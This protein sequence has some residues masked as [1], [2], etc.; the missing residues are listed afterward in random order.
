MC[1]LLVSLF[2]FLV[3]TVGSSPL[4]SPATSISTNGTISA[5]TLAPTSASNTC[6]DIATSRTR[7]TIV[8][9][10]LATILACVWTAVH[11]NVPGL[12]KADASRFWRIMGPVPEAAKI[13]VVTL[14]VPEWVLA[15][16]VR[17]FLTARA[18]E[19]ELEAA[20]SDAKAVWDAKIE[21]LR[22]MT[23]GTAQKEP[24]AVIQRYHKDGVRVAHHR[25]PRADWTARHGF[26]VITGGFHY[27]ENGEPQC[28]LSRWDAIEL[29]KTGGLVP[30]TEQEIRG[31]SQRN[32]LSK[33]F[34]VIQ[35]LWFIVQAAARSV[36]GPSLTQLAI[37]TLGYTTIT[38]AMYIAWWD[39]PQ[40]IGG[41]VRVSVKRLPEPK[42]AVELGRLRRLFRVIAGSQDDDVDLRRKRGVPTF[43]SGRN[44]NDDYD[45]YGDLVALA[46]AMVF[47]A[48]HC[49]AWNN[50]FPSHAEQV[51]WRFS[52]LAIIALPGVMLAATLL[53]WSLTWARA[54]TVVKVAFF[55][56]LVLAF[57]VVA[58]VYVAARSLLLVLSFT[59]L[60]SLPLD[61]YEAVQWTLLIPHFT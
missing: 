19:R 21:L 2:P 8:C 1:L 36:E 56:M 46:A 6:T 58:P 41:P 51:I 22:E 54:S 48:V 30:P 5:D 60:R 43:Y 27:Y 18:V 53:L 17:Q 55:F 38:V 57:V 15:W 9:S 44:K 3:D 52:S 40:N 25:V 33:I 23:R 49:A 34:A 16:A 14:L 12:S 47:G 26:L 35:T 32:A 11:R 45:L 61:A 29:A 39:K 59:T 4:A 24:T 37:M 42:P 13:V 7:R 28:P 20:R 50:T 10:S 31:W